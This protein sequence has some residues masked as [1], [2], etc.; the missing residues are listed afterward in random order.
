MALKS[1]ITAQ[2]DFDAL[3][4]A[5][6]AEYKKEGDIWL[7]DSDDATELRTAKDREAKRAR[8]AEAE[9]DRLKKEAEDAA[10]VIQDAKD[11]AA[12]KAGD[13]AAIEKSWSDK[14]EAEKTE[15]K[16]REAALQAQIDTLLV[17]NVANQ[18]AGDIST[19]PDLLSG[20]IAKRLKAEITDGVAITRVLDAD[21]KPSAMSI[22]E[23]KKEFVANPKYAAIIQGSN[24]SGGGANGGGTGGGAPTGKKF[25]QL[26]EAERVALHR[27]NPT[28]FAELSAKGKAGEDATV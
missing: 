1:K 15:G 2:A 11:E 28:K 10:R 16:K 21:G 26:S 8:D 7:L 17:T 23:L 18:I 12:R 5:I 14:Y 4:D 20:P 19:V 22:D 6:K 3:P 27:E 9:R 13:V 25:S 24:A